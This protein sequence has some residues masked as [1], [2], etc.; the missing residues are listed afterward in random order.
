MDPGKKE[1]QDAKKVDDQ[2][3]QN[4]A[5]EVVPQRFSLHRRGLGNDSNEKG[6]TCQG[7]NY[8]ME[9]WLGQKSS[10]EAWNAVVSY[11]RRH[12]QRS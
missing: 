12:N 8:S 7:Y 9:R 10:E 11:E 2:A 5:E 3:V 4:S 1:Q 6:C